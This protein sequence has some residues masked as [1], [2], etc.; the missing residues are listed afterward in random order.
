[1][2][3]C[4]LI[5]FIVFLIFGCQPKGKIEQETPLPQTESQF[6]QQV[7]SEQIA[8]D[9]T[10]EA[11]NK[12]D[13]KQQ[14]VQE[15]KETNRLYKDISDILLEIK[16]FDDH[17]KVIISEYGQLLSGSW[18]SYTDKVDGVRELSWGTVPFAN[19]GYT[20]IDFIAEQPVYIEGMTEGGPIGYDY[21][22]AKVLKIEIVSPHMFRIY[23]ID[24]S[25]SFGTEYGDF[26]FTYNSENDTISIVEFGGDIVDSPEI[27]YRVSE[28]LPE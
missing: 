5:T 15:L 3:Q 9:E 17:T 18:T 25:S 24:D 4:F 26:V 22:V 27:E 16:E 19:H 1:M 8:S 6:E 13:S 7:T 20:L 28:K 12:I 11:N 14:N 10:D 2:K 23:Y 21:F